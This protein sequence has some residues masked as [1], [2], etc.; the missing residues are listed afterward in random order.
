MGF[1]RERGREKPLSSRKGRQSQKAFALLKRRK[2]VGFR[3]VRI[4]CE[5]PICHPIKRGINLGLFVTYYM[6]VFVD[7]IIK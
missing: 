3:E 1:E 4:L 5:V 7:L 2:T 6:L